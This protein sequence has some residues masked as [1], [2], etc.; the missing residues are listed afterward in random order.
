MIVSSNRPVS[1]KQKRFIFKGRPNGADPMLVRKP[2]ECMLP[3]HINVDE[4]MDID[5]PR[6]ESIKAEYRSCNGHVAECM[7]NGDD[8]LAMAWES[9]TNFIA[10][11]L[12]SEARRYGLLCSRKAAERT[13]K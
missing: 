2:E 6:L 4:V 12:L 7:A 9:R 3:G 8:M 5:D 11:R 1:Y 13:G 10:S